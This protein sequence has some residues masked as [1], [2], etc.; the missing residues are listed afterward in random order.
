MYAVDA[1]VLVFVFVAVVG[2]LMA[3]IMTTI[4]IFALPPSLLLNGP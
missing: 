3:I 2:W 1:V 4:I